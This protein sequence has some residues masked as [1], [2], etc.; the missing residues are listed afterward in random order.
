MKIDSQL[1]SNSKLL[2]EVQSKL[3]IGNQNELNQKLHTITQNAAK[4]FD[5][6]TSGYEPDSKHVQKM[7]NEIE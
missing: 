3:K 2:I 5:S 6:Y 1:E 7:T 4:N